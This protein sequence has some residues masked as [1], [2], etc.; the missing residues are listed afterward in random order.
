M[1]MGN[2]EYRCDEC[3]KRDNRNWSAMREVVVRQVDNPDADPVKGHVCPTCWKGVTAALPRLTGDPRGAGG[4]SVTVQINGRD[5]VDPAEIG[6]LVAD[7]VRAELGG[8]PA[9]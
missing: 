9:K 1:N 6:R 7:S 2:D 5:T 3:G 8:Q 4:I